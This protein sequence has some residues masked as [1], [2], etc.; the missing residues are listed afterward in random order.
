MNGNLK[1]CPFCGAS[2]RVARATTGFDDALEE[3]YVLLHDNPSGEETKDCPIS[4]DA[5]ESIGSWWWDDEIEAVEAWN[6]RV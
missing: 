2:V 6:M 1:A 5:D 3:H 4:H